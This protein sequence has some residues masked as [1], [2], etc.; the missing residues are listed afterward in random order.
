MLT[1]NKHFYSISGIYAA[2]ITYTIV[3]YS[4]MRN[5]LQSHT[6]LRRVGVSFHGINKEFKQTRKTLTTTYHTPGWLAGMSSQAGKKL[7]RKLRIKY[8]ISDRIPCCTGVTM[9]PG[10]L[11]SCP[12]DSPPLIGHLLEYQ[13]CA[14]DHSSCSMPICSR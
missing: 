12:S 10:L 6:A 1:K 7:N 4:P 14:R 5:V 9:V 8:S 3:F 13:P 11:V 2:S